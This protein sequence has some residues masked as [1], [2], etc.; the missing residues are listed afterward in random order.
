MGFSSEESIKSF[1]EELIDFIKRESFDKEEE[2]EA[3][4][5]YGSME[6]RS[7]TWDKNWLPF[8]LYDKQ[9]ED[10]IFIILLIIN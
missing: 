1:S 10:I 2:K 6:T 5:V 8:I 9:W 7:D 4:I 3:K